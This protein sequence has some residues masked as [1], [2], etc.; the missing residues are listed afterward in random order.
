MKLFKKIISGFT[1]FSM[2]ASVSAASGFNSVLFNGTFVSAATYD[3]V[4]SLSKKTYEKSELKTFSD[5]ELYDSKKHANVTDYSN[6]YCADVPSERI[7]EEYMDNK[8]VEVGLNIDTNSGISG[9]QAILDYDDSLVFAG[10]TFENDGNLSPDKDAKN[11]LF[12]VSSDY[13]KVL[14]FND[15]LDSDYMGT[16][17]FVTLLFI[18]PDDYELEHAYTVGFSE[19]TK[20]QITPSNVFGQVQFSGNPGFIM[21]T[22]KNAS[23]APTEAPVNPTTAPATTAPTAEPTQTP[24]TT[25]P[26]VEPTPV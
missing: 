11:K 26:T 10:C 2:I 12:T 18:L 22:D 4:F 9:L 21:I 16:G 6:L 17:L 20:R 13:D 3:Y 24:A 15:T 8:V 14:F 1:A 7:T 25:A 5:Y 23:S 19:R